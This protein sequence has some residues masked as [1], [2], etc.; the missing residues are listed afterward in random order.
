MSIFGIWNLPSKDSP[1]KC[2]VKGKESSGIVIRKYIFRLLLLMEAYLKAKP[3]LTYDFVGCFF[4][5]TQFISHL[6]FYSCFQNNSWNILISVWKGRE[7]QQES[8]CVGMC[9]FI[10]LVLSGNWFNMHSSLFKS[11][12]KFERHWKCG[13]EE[14][15]ADVKKEAPTS[16]PT[17]I[18]LAERNT[19]HITLYD[20]AST[21]HLLLVSVPRYWI[22][23]VVKGSLFQ[24]I[25]A[26]SSFP[27]LKV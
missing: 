10:S 12:F 2:E 25:R 3:R 26:S 23:E 22:T 6:H 16:T 24:S 17:K 18:P 8:V 1:I 21:W 19:W 14:S 11:S 7:R 20:T 9:A 4:L 15:K 13:L 5:A 27:P